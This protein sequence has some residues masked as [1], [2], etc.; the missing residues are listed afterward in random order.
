M[1]KNS[2][3]GAEIAALVVAFMGTG[4]M[5]AVGLGLAALALQAALRG[6]ALGIK[7]ASWL[8]ASVGVLSVAGA[9]S[10]IAIVTGALS[11]PNALQR[12]T[13]L[14]LAISLVGFG[15]ALIGYD[16]ELLPAPVAA[17]MH[18]LAFGGTS[19]LIILVL[20]R[21]VRPGR[22]GLGPF[23][24]GIWIAPI[25]ALTIEAL[26]AILGIALAVMVFAA[27][28]AGRIW[29]SRLPD[30]SM[31]ARSP[32]ELEQVAPLLRQPLS[33]MLAV[34]GLTVLVPILEEFVKSIW[35]VP[36]AFIGR[37]R[38]LEGFVAGAMAG[39]GFGLAEAMF[40]AQPESGWSQIFLTRL[41]ASLMH[42]T[43]S[44]IVGWGIAEFAVNRRATRLLASYLGAV[45]FH[46]LWNMGALAIATTQL[47]QILS[48]ESPLVAHSE[49]FAGLG[50][51]LIMSLLLMALVGFWTVI[52]QQHRQLASAPDALDSG[53][54]G[55]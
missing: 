2:Y 53:D 3:S 38:P 15:G 23:L 31:L 30:P 36:L 25:L 29:I 11:L 12:A 13:R 16:L 1:I 27:T 40:V 39:V 34:I 24:H 48:A 45:A 46:G 32:L 55:R 20:L 50:V 52:R 17:A 9:V 18:G 28:D 10:A 42:A 22:L 14:S 35:L 6:D 33:I 8:A 7:M 54:P 44:G 47:D 49:L 21:S 4:A 19:A 43:T 51:M 26:L 41:G 37:F 5:A